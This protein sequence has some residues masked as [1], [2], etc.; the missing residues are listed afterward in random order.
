MKER[1]DIADRIRRE[2]DATCLS[3]LTD[4]S[5]IGIINGYNLTQSESYIDQDAVMLLE[6][7]EQILVDRELLTE[8]IFLARLGDDPTESY[9]Q[10]IG[11]EYWWKHM[12]K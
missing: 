11:N 9:Q 10:E 12:P 4:L 1:F 8:E 3:L 2:A 5:R 6:R 7:T